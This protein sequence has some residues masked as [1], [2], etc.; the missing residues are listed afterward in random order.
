MS[1]I[2]VVT[3][4]IWQTLIIDREDWGRER[5]RLRIQGAIDAL[6]NAG[7]DFTEEQVREAYR[8]CYRACRVI[9][10]EERD[11]SFKEQVQMFVQ[12]IS[13]GL[14]ERVDRETF[15]RILNRYA[16]AFFDS[17]PA[18]AEGA[19]DT[20]LRLKEQ[21]Y[22]LGV[23]S[24][25]TTTPG[26]LLRSYL[27]DLELVQYFDHM[28]FSDEVL[29]SKPSPAIFQHTLV[30]MGCLAEQAIHVGDHLHNDI[31]GAQRAGIRSAWIEGYDDSKAE[32]A[33][34]VTLQ[35]IS[36][37]PAALEALNAG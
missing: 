11:I 35:R 20:L 34:T 18:V 24:N 14:L 2:H 31:L 33:P 15:A 17:P 8:A 26:R 1:P 9:R 16:D 10:H 32:V 4:D 5:S 36:E 19:A 29:L 7:E 23:I 25:T 21:D 30:S 3:F 13:P 28:T 12:R 6:H 37:L 22:R 27:E